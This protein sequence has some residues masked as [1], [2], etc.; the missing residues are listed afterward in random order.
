MIFDAIVKDNFVKFLS[1]VAYWYCIEMQ[2]MCFHWLI[3][4]RMTLINSFI[5]S[6]CVV[7]VDSLGF[8]IEVTVHSVRK[9]IF[10]LYSLC[11]WLFIFW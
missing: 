10:F 1:P 5:S 6:T 9:D 3:L 7:C 2:L 11:A 4:Y 8:S